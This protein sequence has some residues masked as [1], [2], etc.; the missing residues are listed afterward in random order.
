MPGS[1]CSWSKNLKLC[2]EAFSGDMGGG[3]EGQVWE[4]SGSVASEVPSILA[5]L[6]T[7]HLYQVLFEGRVLWQ[8]EEEERGVRGEGWIG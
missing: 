5:A 7:R 1:Y 8:E 4:W 3:G 6:F 2:S